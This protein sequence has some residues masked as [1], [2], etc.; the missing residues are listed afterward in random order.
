MWKKWWHPYNPLG[1]YADSWIR[2]LVGVVVIGFV[3]GVISYVN[4][5]R[6]VQKSIRAAVQAAVLLQKAQTKSL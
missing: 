2:V 6:T 4:F 5:Y 1:W 3:L